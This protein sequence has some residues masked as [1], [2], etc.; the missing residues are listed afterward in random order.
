MKTFDVEAFRKHFPILTQQIEQHNLVYFDNAATMQKPLSVI[1]AERQFYLTTNAN[2]HRG[3][4]TLSSMATSLFELARVK[5]QKFINASS[6]KEIIW[7]KGTTESINLIAQAWGSE[8]L[9]PGDEIVLSYAEHHANIVPWQAIAKQKGA[10]IKWLVL[11]EAGRIDRAKLTQVIGNKT[12]IVCC[13][14]LSNVVGKFNPVEYLIKCAK[15]VGALTLVDGAQAVAHTQVDVQKLGCDFYVFSAHKLYGPTGVGVLYGRQSLL[16]QVS[17]YQFGGE[18]IKTVSVNE[19]TYNELPFKF[20][21]GTPNI[22]GCIAFAQAIEFVSQHQ[23][24]SL[25]QYKQQLT[26]YCY[27]QLAAISAVR[28]VVK[29]IPDIPLISFY[30]DNAHQQDVAAA[31]DAKGIAIRA[32]HH[33]AMP[34]MSYLDLSG[35]LRISLSAYNT[36]AE[37]DYLIDCL[38]MLMTE[39][40]EQS[41]IASNS[42]PEEQVSE[43]LALFAKQQSWDNKHRQ[44]MLLGK[45]LKRMEKA[46][47]TEERLITGCESAAWLDI[48]QIA[49]GRYLLRGDSD[50]KIIRGL[51]VIV[52]SAFNNKTAEQILAFDI[53]D[54][55]LQ[56]GLLKHLSPSRGNGLLAI[57][58]K[59]KTSVS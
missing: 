6:A 11:D 21:A 39:P 13:S 14:H 1:E 28:F 31:L 58:E 27:Q 47:R 23:Q 29:E 2:V 7:T 44:I 4:H 30:L 26:R 54:Y 5:V 52:F 19:T 57:V 51:M 38:K 12:K 41:N 48:S 36:I 8:F 25:Y 42:A 18:M 55:F 34:L 22:A 24:K 45:T 17:P 46:L 16:E 15:E 40:A 33:C 43:I 9:S 35:C 50:A 32:G 20:E 49:G 3:A 10:K 53:H 59:I 37:I 56:L